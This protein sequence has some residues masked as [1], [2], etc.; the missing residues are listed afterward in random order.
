MAG[1]RWASAGGGPPGVHIH[2]HQWVTCIGQPAAWHTVQRALIILQPEDLLGVADR[3]E[4][5]APPQR[6]SLRR[7]LPF[8]D[9][10]GY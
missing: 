6:P 9:H 2:I 4:R 5:L 3:E 8:G 7:L 1:G 10:D